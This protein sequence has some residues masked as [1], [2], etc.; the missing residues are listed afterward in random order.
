MLDWER[1]WQFLRDLQGWM[2]VLDRVLK[3]R[4]T[5]EGWEGAEGRERRKLQY[6]GAGVFA[7]APLQLR[8][9]YGTTSSHQRRQQRAQDPARLNLPT[10]TLLCCLES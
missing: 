3:V 8:H 4:G 5:G 1:P 7:D 10:P 6:G 9:T 2:G